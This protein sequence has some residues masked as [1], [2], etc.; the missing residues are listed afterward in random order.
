VVS[1]GNVLYDWDLRHGVSVWGGKTRGKI[2]GLSLEGRRC[3]AWLRGVHPDDLGK[4]RGQGPGRAARDGTST[5]ARWE[6]SSP[7]RF[8]TRHHIDVAHRRG[9]PPEGR[10]VRAIG[11]LKDGPERNRAEAGAPGTHW[12]RTCS[13]LREAQKMEASGHHGRGIAHDLSTIS[14]ARSSATEAGQEADA[15]AGSKLRLQ[16]QRRSRK[17]ARRRARP[18]LTRSSPSLGRDAG[19]SGPRA[20]AGV[21]R[22][23][24]AAPGDPARRHHT[25][26]D[27]RS[28][29]AV[30][31]D[32]THVYQMC[33]FG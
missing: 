17:P 25:P 13:R 2:W 14:W 32:A 27:T 23:G 7:A 6:L 33:R 26:R 24:S 3:S 4:I 18:W 21:A 8:G 31:A 11:F 10:A 9:H 29:A 19:R 20:V 1:A 15:P 22:C 28:S 30:L 16:L 12:R 5:P